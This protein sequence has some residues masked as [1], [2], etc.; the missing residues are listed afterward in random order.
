[1]VVVLA[2]NS[3]TGSVIQTTVTTSQDASI[4]SKA[5]F[6]TATGVSITTN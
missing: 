5:S 1:V 6:A 3:S 2:S 4:Y